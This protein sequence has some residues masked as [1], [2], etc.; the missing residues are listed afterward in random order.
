[1]NNIFFIVFK[2]AVP[3]VS[4]VASLAFSRGKMV[5]IAGLEPAL[6]LFVGLYVFYWT[7]DQLKP[8]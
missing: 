7:I 1:M 2:K 6:R 4:P 3:A 5:R 8:A